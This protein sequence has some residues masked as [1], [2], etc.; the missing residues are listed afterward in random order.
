MT[1]KAASTL[2]CWGLMV[3]MPVTGAA[4]LMLTLWRWMRRNCARAS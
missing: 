3:E 4:R 1:F 2:A